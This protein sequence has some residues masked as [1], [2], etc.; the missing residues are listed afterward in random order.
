[1]PHCQRTRS[2]SDIS[3]SPTVIRAAR[4]T[5]RDRSAAALEVRTARRRLR[6]RRGAER[7]AVWSEFALRYERFTSILCAAAKDGATPVLEQEFAALRHWFAHNYRSIVP[8]LRPHLE[9]VASE[10]FGRP[11]GPVHAADLRPLDPFEALFHAGGL[12]SLLRSDRGGLIEQVS[13]VSEAVWHCDELIAGA[14]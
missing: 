14:A 13:C 4:L 9:K 2:R 8:Y 5:S 1:M 7:A 6:S 11:S 3:H 10:R 12:E